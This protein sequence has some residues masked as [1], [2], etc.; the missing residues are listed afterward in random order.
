[1]DVRNCRQCGRIYNYIGGPYKHLCPDCVRKMEDK[2]VEVKEYINEYD[3]AT[4]A[5]VSAEC[6]VSVKQIEKWVR[7]E[8]LC[9]SADSPIGIAC[10]KCGA[11]IKSGRFCD[12]CKGSM[13]NSFSNAYREEKPQPNNAAQER[14]E[15]ARMRF[16]EQ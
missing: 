11:M 15:K 4:I 5:E 9:F 8:R 10:E 13:A 2:F 16:L 1:M 14:R 6:D 12:N 3:K 7:E